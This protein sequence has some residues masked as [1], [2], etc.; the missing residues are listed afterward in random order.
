MAERSPAGKRLLS[1]SLDVP[2]RALLF[3]LGSLAMTL[4]RAVELRLGPPLGRF[5]LRLGLFRPRIAHDNIRRC[6]PE[7]GPAGWQALLRRNY[8]HYG[9]LFFEFLHF[10][11]PARAHYRDYARRIARLEGYENWRRAH[12]Q[13]RG[14]LFVA[15]HV[16][17]WEM[18]AAAGGLAGMPLTVVT[19]VLKPAWLHEKIAAA[20]RTT[21]VAHAYHPGSMP[22]VLRALRRGDSVAFMND[23][24]A[25]PPM[26]VPARFFGVEVA[27]LAAVG[28]LARRTGAAVVP[29]SSYR[30]R[31]GLVRVVVEP[32]LDVSAC[33]NDTPAVT[34]LVAAK[35]EGWVR[36]HP[37]QW[38]WIHRRFK[39][40]DWSLKTP[41]EAHA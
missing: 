8:E 40:V 41:E 10:F 25:P 19:T 24:Y 28:A 20:R 30:D 34:G 9:V 13:G 18:L 38:L 31:D 29:V 3:V 37:E 39:N 1:W 6:L 17:F 36:S 27:T 2:L 5:I 23:Q 7:L 4:P 32:E 35:V 26:G 14:V 12:D 15:S 11:A 33:I 21:G 16:G 22:A